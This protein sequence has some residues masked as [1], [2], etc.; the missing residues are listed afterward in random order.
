MYQ[1]GNQCSRIL[2]AAR[3]PQWIEISLQD[4]LNVR[5]ELESVD[6]GQPQRHE[7]HSE[8][9]TGPD[10]VAQQ[11][12][13]WF[14]REDRLQ[15]RGVVARRLHRIDRGVRDTRHPYFSVRPPL[16]AHPVDDLDR[17]LLLA[18]AE[19]IPITLGEA[20]STRVD[21]DL[22]VSVL[23]QV[24]VDAENPCASAGDDA[25]QLRH[26]VERRSEVERVRHVH[27][28][29]THLGDRQS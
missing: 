12:V 10:D 13:A 4:V 23:D 25:R 18:L 14:D 27:Q 26:S 11:I 9:T 5:D 22:G 29:L 17:I 16:L 15:R 28:R 1:F 2:E 8:A 24:T 19:D 20:G 3:Q 6:R 21:H 7:P